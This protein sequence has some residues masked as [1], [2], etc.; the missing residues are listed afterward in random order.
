ML[1][2]KTIKASFLH[3]VV[4]EAEGDE[5]EDDPG[6]GV[7]ADDEDAEDGEE[8][9]EEDVEDEGEAVVDRVEVGREAVED[10]PDRRGV[11]KRRPVSSRFDRKQFCPSFG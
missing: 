5:E 3:I 1:S 6:D 4:N 2:K 8:A 11:E 10:P 7:D 9:R